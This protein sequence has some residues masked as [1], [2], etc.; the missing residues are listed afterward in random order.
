MKINSEIQKLAKL[1]RSYNSVLSGIISFEGKYIIMLDGKVVEVFDNADR[2]NIYLF[3][4]E[5]H[6]LR[7]PQLK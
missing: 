3:G 6:L 1:I 2:A 4:A 5:Y 7:R